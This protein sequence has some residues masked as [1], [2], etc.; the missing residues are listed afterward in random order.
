MSNKAKIAIILIVIA[1]FWGFGFWLG[2]K[3][4]KVIT[5]TKVE[6]VNSPKITGVIVKPQP[7]RE[8]KPIDTLRIV[9]ECI[10]KGIY[11]EL[12][13][14]REVIKYVS[15]KSDSTAIMK[16][17][18]TIREYRDTLFNND[19]TGTFVLSSR[20]QY[21]RIEKYLYEYSTIT[22]IV[23]NTERVVKGFS[24]FAGIGYI[25]D[26]FG[27]VN[28]GFYIKEKYGFS[29]IYERDFINGRNHYGGMISIK[30]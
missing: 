10:A 30:F 9:E 4:A 13:P 15:D 12:F 7:I 2:R 18:A 28:G 24:P 25:S 29:G 21:N 17:W 6:Y 22:K 20:I 14:Q 3:Q 19:T 26:G 1:L 16:D 8:I 27:I 5:K 11:T 23:T